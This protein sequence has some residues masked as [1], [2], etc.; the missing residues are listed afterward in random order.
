MS[1]TDYRCTEKK[2]ATVPLIV[3]KLIEAKYKRRIKRL[4]IALTASVATTILIS[5]GVILWITAS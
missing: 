4:T 2:I 1:A 3:H 5:I